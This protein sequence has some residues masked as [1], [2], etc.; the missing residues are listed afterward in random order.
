MEVKLTTKPSK[1]GC[2]GCF[3]EN[4]DDCPAGDDYKTADFSKCV[5]E[6]GFPIIFIPLNE[7]DKG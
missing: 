2:D 1:A 7:E 5:D 6:T 4:R 3:Y